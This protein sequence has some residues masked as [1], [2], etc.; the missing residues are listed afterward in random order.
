[1][2]AARTSKVPRTVP[3]IHPVLPPLP[4]HQPL[5]TAP[6]NQPEYGDSL[7]HRVPSRRCGRFGQDP[8]EE[9]DSPKERRGDHDPTSS[10]SS[11]DASS[12]SC[13]SCPKNSPFHTCVFHPM[14]SA[15]IP[16]RLPKCPWT[17]LHRRKMSPGQRAAES[18]LGV[19]PRHGFSGETFPLTAPWL[20]PFAANR[21]QEN[22]NET[23]SRSDGN[24]SASA[25]ERR[26]VPRS[27][28]EP[29]TN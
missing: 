8:Q 21:L 27:G 13:E 19:P 26:M 24:E 25:I 11:P 1:M 20:V 18:V 9:Q 29:E 3:Q 5:T 17:P 2:P 4:P 10:R 14:K 28:L 6:T 15:V 12:A 7:G 22:P 23:S 16:L